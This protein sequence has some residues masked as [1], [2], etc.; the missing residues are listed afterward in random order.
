MT[1]TNIFDT[2][3]TNHID[4]D[5]HPNGK[6][7]YLAINKTENRDRLNYYNVKIVEV[8]RITRKLTRI[9]R[10][11][12]Q[13]VHTPGPVGY[14]TVKCL[15]DGGL[16][17]GLA[18]TSIKDPTQV[19]AAFDIIENSIP[20][21]TPGSANT[22][23]PPIVST[24]DT[25]ARAD[26]LTA[27]TQSTRALQAAVAAQNRADSAHSIATTAI[28]KVTELS[29]RTDMRI[30]QLPSKEYV[31]Q[32]IADRIA[33]EIKNTGTDTSS[34]FESPL[35]MGFVKARAQEVLLDAIKYASANPD[36]SALATLI[37][38]IIVE[39]K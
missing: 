18:I 20:V 14:C 5:V 6:L 4:A 13:G 19:V 26:A 39:S 7:V 33:L 16:F 34:V 35:F 12:N 38:K 17:V 10:E 29:L 3:Y 9:L 2:G 28:Q 22:T 8:D 36:K 27:L 25:Q 31:W 24:V 23:V 37:K 11:Y 21:F 32:N 30:A 1:I 15:P